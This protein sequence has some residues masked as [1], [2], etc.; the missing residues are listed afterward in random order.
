MWENGNKERYTCK[1]HPFFV[2]YKC[3]AAIGVTLGQLNKTFLGTSK[4]E[5]LSLVL[6]PYPRLEK[7]VRD[8]HSSLLRTFVNYNRQKLY[9]IGTR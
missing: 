6:R 5:P 7:T 2:A 3:D 1:S 4:V 8:K 9:D